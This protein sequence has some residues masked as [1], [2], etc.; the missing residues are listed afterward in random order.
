M[1]TI[2]Q[3]ATELANSG[4]SIM[5]IHAHDETLGDKR[6]ALSWKRLQTERLTPTEID[7]WFANGDYGIGVVMGAISNDLMMIEL[8]GRAATHLAELT[9]LTKDSGLDHLWQ[10]MFGWCEITPSGGYHWYLYAPGNT[11]GNRKLARNAGGEVIAETRENGG[12]SVV[13][14]LD[15]TRF[16]HTRQGAWK[17]ITGGPATAGTF[18]PDELDDL[19]AVFQ[20]LDETPQTTTTTTTPAY[21]P[22]AD[23][24]PHAGISPGDDYETKTSWTDILTPHGWTPVHQRGTETF[25]RRP[26][27]THGISASTGHAQDRDRLYVWSSSTSFEP[28]TPYTKFGSYAILEHAGDYTAAAKHLASKGYGKQAEHPRDT[29]GLDQ[30]IDNHTTTADTETNEPPAAATITGE[31]EIYT[32]TDDGN[33][34]RLADTHQ[35][36]LIYIPQL[37]TWAT[38]N[39]YQYSTDGGDETAVE[40]ARTLARNL[41]EDDKADSA[42]K[43]RSLNTNTI[44][45]ML[46]L[47]RNDKRMYAPLTTFDNDP[48]TLNTPAGTINLKTGELTPHTRPARYLRA[49][50][51]A[52]DA[53]PAPQWHAFLAQTF[54]NETEVIA[55]VQRALGLSLIGTVLEQKFFLLHGA[56]ANGKSTLMNIIQHLLGTGETGYTDT[57]PANMLIKGGG[58]RHPTELAALTGVRIAVASELEQ[59]QTVHEAKFKLLT[60]RDYITARRMHQDFYTF[61]PTH[62]MFLS[63][64]HEPEVKMGGSAF[65]RRMQKVPFN[66][67]VPEHQQNPNLEQELIEEEGPQILQWLIDGARTYIADGLNPPETVRKATARYELEQ[68]TV[69]QFLNEAC[70]INLDNPDMYQI[71]ISTFRDAYEAWCESNGIEPVGAKTLTQRLRQDGIDSAKGS[72]GQRYYKGI[73]FNPEFENDLQEAIQ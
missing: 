35:G 44:L 38:W 25:W 13:A 18:T 66:N 7:Q 31:P 32:R 70:T 68:D 49:T 62:S 12:Y 27:K 60:G 51:L 5:P 53:G 54:T 59:G 56:G 55:Y 41:P 29:T 34:L 65:W 15:G 26:D 1:T 16:H 2:H 64:N 22:P 20:T 39:G 50:S 67:V 42:H 30:W 9:T 4:I 57:I 17:A 61:A 63:T 69:Q 37:G 23:R 36:E 45:N 24:D 46:K 28:E 52:P 72:G 19:L 43:R 14:P 33:A 40:T 21:T 48:Y 73:M 11:S 6:P 47:A 8:E 58:D 10:R 71:R 3:R